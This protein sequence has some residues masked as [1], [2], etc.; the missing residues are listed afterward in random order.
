MNAI[1]HFFKVYWKTF[2]LWIFLVIVAI[3]LRTTGMDTHILTAIMFIVGILTHAFTE[4]ISLI[5]LIPVIG[6]PLVKII[7]LPFFII[8]NFLSYVFSYFVVSRSGQKGLFSSKIVG[9]AFIIG[10]LMGYILGRL[11]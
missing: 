10:L 1:K 4:L 9:T 5:S 11:L 3:V 7:S 6:P 2:L 8:I